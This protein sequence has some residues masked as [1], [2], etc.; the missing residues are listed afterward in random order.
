[1][2]R[3]GVSPRVKLNP[4]NLRCDGGATALFA[5]LIFSFNRLFEEAFDALHHPL[6]RPHAAH[7]DVAVVGVAREAMAAS[8]QLFVQHVEHQIRQKR[9][10]RAAL[11]GSFV[12][13]AD[14][15]VRQHAAGQKPRG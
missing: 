10:E 15:P 5:S 7:I 9:R 14:Q 13:G 6:A 12:R 11:R 3:R 2:R 8:L 1:M 4:K